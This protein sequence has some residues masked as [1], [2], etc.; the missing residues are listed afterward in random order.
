MNPN[1][2]YGFL[3]IILYKYWFINYNKCS[4]VIEDVNTKAGCGGG[5]SRRDMWEH[6]RFSNQFF[7][8]PNIFL[9]DKGY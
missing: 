9:K 6:S 7:C 8:K 3:L 2:N 1:V 5:G 4:L